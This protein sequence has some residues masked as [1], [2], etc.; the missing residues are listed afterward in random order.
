MGYTLTLASAASVNEGNP[1]TTAA[2]FTFNLTR[3]AG[4]AVE[5]TYR[6]SIRNASDFT[7]ATDFA[8]NDNPTFDW[9]DD[10]L[11]KS[12]TIT[13]NPDTTV[14]G[15]ESF[16]VWFYRDGVNTPQVT[17]STFTLA[18]DDAGPPVFSSATN[19]NAAEN[20]T[21]AG[22]VAAS[23]SGVQYSIVGGADQA[24]FTLNAS[25]G[26][27]T[28]NAPNPNFEAPSD[29]GA[30]GVY[31]LIVRAEAGGATTDQNLTVTLTNVN[32]A[33]TVVGGD[34]VAANVNE[35]TTAVL[36][37]AATDLDAGDSVS[38][39]IAG[40]ADGSLFQIDA[41]GNLSF[42]TAPNREGAHAPAYS[43]VI[44]ATDSGGLSDTQQVNVTVDDVP[45]GA[46]ITSNGGGDFVVMHVPE[47]TLTT[48]TL[49][50]V[51]ARD[52]EGDPRTYAIGGADA[53][54]F[55]ID[56]TTGVLT[57]AAS[58]NYEVPNDANGDHLYEITVSATSAGGPADVQTMY[59]FL[60][61]VIEPG[62]P[63]DQTTPGGGGTPG[64]GTPG[65]G[66]PGNGLGGTSGPDAIT[67]TD[68]AELRAG[69]DGDDTILGLGGSD[70][71][72]GDNGADL[73]V[74][75]DGDDFIRG[76]NDNDA[77]Y[78]GA[79]SDT[80][81]GNL[82]D[83]LVDGGEGADTVYGG[84]GNDNVFGGDG[85]DV[86]VNGNI[87]ND[88]VHGGLGNDSVY[89]GQNNDTVFGDEG[90]DRVSGDL[91]DDN[92]FGGAGADLFVMAKGFGHDW[93]GD[94]NAAEGDHVLLAAGTAY[95]VTDYFGQVLIDLGGG[96]TIGLAGVPFA[97][98]NASWVVFG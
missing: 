87:G 29:A 39:S 80:V 14:E 24:L 98:F 46:V 90:V 23:G 21:A 71:L 79:G 81:N 75:G 70:W 4:D 43:V 15:N 74:G 18:N 77:V 64:G 82:G 65:G 41:S 34:T 27:L 48:T 22:T 5:D 35:N 33:I 3:Q 45:E 78:G 67:G 12:F 37:A 31:D 40:G 49:A 88:T 73:I 59:L 44:R 30:N 8:V 32:E 25:T 11:T 85:D 95:T 26:A 55:A 93:V 51:T 60:D 47:N 16:V 52:D 68:S 89:G 63:S 54:A 1:S 58:P 61:N 62:E 50:T 57:F 83:D 7:V 20:Q 56:A 66:T 17:S 6:W 13:A 38:W 28:F 9:S 86:Y 76:L 42:R 94:F 36:M 2:T 53:A 92:L 69:G 97:S 96:D 19:F 10:S 72:D 91:G 84:Q